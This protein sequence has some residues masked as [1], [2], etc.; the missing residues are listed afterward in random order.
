M[1][2][3]SFVD[4]KILNEARIDQIGHELLKAAEA[5][6][7]RV[8]LNFDSVQFMS[9]AMI[10]NLVFLHKR[11]KQ[12]R[13]GAALVIYNLPSNFHELCIM[14]MLHK[15]FTIKNSVEAALALFPPEP[16]PL[17]WTRRIVILL[18]A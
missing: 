5:N 9:S 3:I 16:A 13:S 6:G 4:A 11:I 17:I 7:W 18:P 10:V 2:E 12:H 15:A 1:L 8:F 14:M